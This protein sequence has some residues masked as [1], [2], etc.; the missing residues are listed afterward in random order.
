MNKE[1]ETGIINLYQITRKVSDWF[2]ILVQVTLKPVLFPLYKNG[3][4]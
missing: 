3:V 1:T 4:Q 2:E